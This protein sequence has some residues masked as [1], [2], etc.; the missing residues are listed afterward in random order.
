MGFVPASLGHKFGLLVHRG[1]NALGR[2][3]LRQQFFSFLLCAGVDAL[4]HFPPIWSFYGVL[5]SP[6]AFFALPQVS[7]APVAVLAPLSLEVR[8]GAAGGCL[9][10][11]RGSLHFA[12]TLVDFGGQCAFA[13][14]PLKC[15]TAAT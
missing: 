2:Y 13:H 8:H 14:P 5:P 7:A 10:A 6:S 15:R 12:N 1:L 9:G 3:H 4:S 11:F